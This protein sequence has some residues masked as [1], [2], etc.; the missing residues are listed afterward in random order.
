MW[1]TRERLLAVAGGA[2]LAVGIAG[3]VAF[4]QTPDS[5]SGTTPP[6]SVAPAQ[7]PDTPASGQR[8]DGDCPDKG[9]SQGTRSTS[10]STTPN[11]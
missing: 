11:F 1:S 2:V 8:G 9:G 6:D 10:T 3:G 7:T 5:G 4:A